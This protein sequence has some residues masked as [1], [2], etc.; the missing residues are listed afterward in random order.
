M[1]FVNWSPDGAPIKGRVLYATAKESF[2]NYLNLNTKD[3]TVCSKGDVFFYLIF[4]V[5]RKRPY[6]RTRS[7]IIWQ[8]DFL[9]IYLSLF[10]I[11]MTN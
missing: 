4:L 8:D 7:L 11:Q 1:I 6:Q 5:N 10:F 2:K 3:F 9:F